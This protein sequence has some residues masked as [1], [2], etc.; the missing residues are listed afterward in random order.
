MI[1]DKLDETFLM[2]NGD[3]LANIDLNDFV[4][5]HDEKKGLATIALTAVPDPSRFGVARLRGDNILEFVEKPPPGKE[6]SNLINAG[7]Y[8]LEPEVL[9]YIPKG[10]AMMERD[11]FPKLAKKGKL[12]G[13]HFDGQWYDTGTPEAYE[14]AIKNWKGVE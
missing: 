1:K 3:V 14:K 9:R 11:V 5:F 7:V 10:K 12:Y 8:V 2:F 4:S 13:Y 6:A